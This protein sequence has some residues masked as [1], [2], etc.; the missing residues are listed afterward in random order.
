MLEVG[1]KGFVA[2]LCCAVLSCFLC[3]LA[4]VCVCDV[5]SLLVCGICLRRVWRWL[6][7]LLRC[8]RFVVFRCL[9]VFVQFLV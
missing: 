6:E 1:L 8:V 4:V 5:F 7:F 3:V 2:L 9:R